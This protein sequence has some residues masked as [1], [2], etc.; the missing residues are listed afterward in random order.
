MVQFVDGGCRGYIA[1]QEVE[2]R[3]GDVPSWKD[4]SDLRKALNVAP[5]LLT[6]D[7]IAVQDAHAHVVESCEGVDAT[8]C[9]LVGWA[10]MLPAC[11]V[12]VNVECI[13]GS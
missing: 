12:L 2:N 10:T 13:P 8:H 7:G 11:A 9:M 3:G 5:E 4:G 1:I 6:L